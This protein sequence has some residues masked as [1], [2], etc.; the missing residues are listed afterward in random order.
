MSIEKWAYKYHNKEIIDIKQELTEQQLE[1][2]EKL[3]IEVKDKIYT[4]YEYDCLKGDLSEYIQDED[5]EYEAKSLEEKNVSKE[6]F[7]SLIKKIDE[8]A[9][10]M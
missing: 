8:I 5:D 1:T 10:K 7:D 6:E 2:I 4:E 3:G 9:S